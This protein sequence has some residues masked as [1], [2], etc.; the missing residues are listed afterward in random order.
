MEII[1]DTILGGDQSESTMANFTLGTPRSTKLLLYYVTTRAPRRS[2]EWVLWELSHPLLFSICSTRRSETTTT[3]TLEIFIFQS[4]VFCTVKCFSHDHV[5]ESFQIS[6]RVIRT[7]FP[8]L[9]IFALKHIV[10]YFFARILF[11]TPAKKYV[12]Y[13]KLIKKAANIAAPRLVR[14]CLS[15]MAKIRRSCECPFEPNGVRFLGAPRRKYERSSS[16]HKIIERRD[17]ATSKCHFFARAKLQHAIVA[18]SVSAM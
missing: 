11:F 16:S 6:F 7:S 9:W 18:A 15:F 13:N 14:Y 3:Y 2:A 5:T 10:S 4:L 12:K 17:I 8:K 1:I